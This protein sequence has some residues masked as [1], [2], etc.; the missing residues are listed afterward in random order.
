MLTTL[1]GSMVAHMFAGPIADKLGTRSA[2]EIFTKTIV[3]RGV[4][5]IQSGDTPRTVEQKL[6]TFLKPS[7]RELGTGTEE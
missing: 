6:K 7:M 5:S 3:I 1:Y 2:E 4:M